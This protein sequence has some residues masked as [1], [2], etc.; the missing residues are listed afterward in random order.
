MPWGHP[1]G[2]GDANAD[3]QEVTFPR[4]GGWVPPG[5]PFQWGGWVPPV[6]PFQPPAP[7]QP[8]GG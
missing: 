2:S 7:I 3:D 4:G 6:Q 1:A 5:Q 8:D